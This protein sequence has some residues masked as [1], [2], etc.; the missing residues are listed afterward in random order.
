MKRYLAAAIAAAVVA[1]APV[2]Q[3]MAGKA[4]DTMNVVWERELETLDNYFNTAREG[5]IVS[6]MVWDSLI[7]RNPQTLEYEPLLATS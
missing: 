6:R 4:D 3:A 7:Y 2:P 1:L 5:I